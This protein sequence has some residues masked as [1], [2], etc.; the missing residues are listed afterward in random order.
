[1]ISPEP[2]EIRSIATVENRRDHRGRASAEKNISI[3]HWA[4]SYGLNAPLAPPSSHRTM[5]LKM[6]KGK[7]AAI[8]RQEPKI[9]FMKRL[10]PQFER[11]REPS[12]RFSGDAADNQRGR[13]L[14]QV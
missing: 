11:K 4:G 7:L 3:D 14:G 12:Q 6:A 5:I 9:R 8:D 10:R 1:L 13:V 2:F